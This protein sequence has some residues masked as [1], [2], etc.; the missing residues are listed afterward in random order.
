MRSDFERPVYVVRLVRFSGSV[1][2]LVLLE[3]TTRAL[4]YLKWSYMAGAAEPSDH[5]PT[6][7]IN[8]S[9]G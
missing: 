6:G 8:T 7:T 3:A 5:L 2:D 4:L 1:S 9:M